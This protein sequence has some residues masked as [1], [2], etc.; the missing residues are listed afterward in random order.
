MW[1]ARTW[2]WLQNSA[3]SEIF[4]VMDHEMLAHECDWLMF[5][6]V[7]L[8]CEYEKETTNEIVLAR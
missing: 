3:R 2:R 5:W 6:I 1:D 4:L 8:G 7:T